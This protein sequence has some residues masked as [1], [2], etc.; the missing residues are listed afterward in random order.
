MKQ[1]LIIVLLFSL[2]SCGVEQRIKDY[3]Y[4]NKWYYENNIRYQ[5]YQTKRGNP[6]IIVLNKDES[7]FKRKYIKISL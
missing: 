1:F 5:V 2:S 6:Y 7:K 4:T 3:S